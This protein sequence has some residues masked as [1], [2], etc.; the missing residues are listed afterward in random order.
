[1]KNIFFLFVLYLLSNF[2]SYYINEFFIIN[3]I[4]L[5]LY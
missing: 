3:E 4:F 2:F 5:V 1:M